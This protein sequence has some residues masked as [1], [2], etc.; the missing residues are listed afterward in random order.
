MSK[1]I[2]SCDDYVFTLSNELKEL[3]AN[4]LRETA[5]SRDHALK[6]MREWIM[7]NPRI[8]N[9]RLDANFL[10]RFLRSKKFS[11]PITQ[12]SLERYLLLRQSYDGRIFRNMDY[13]LNPTQELITNG[14]I[15]ALPQ[16]D[17]LGRR[18]VLTRPGVFDPYK[19]ANVD[20]LKIHG[21]TY[22]VL[23]ENEENQI[24]GFVHIVDGAGVNLPYMTI[25]TPKEAVRIVKNAERTL[26]MRHKEIKAFNLHGSI[27]FAV[28]FALGLVS[29]KMKN[30]IRIYTSVESAVKTVD[31]SLLPKEY[32]GVTPMSDMIAMWQDELKASRDVIL[33][34]DKMQVNLEMYSAKARQGAVS[35]LT[36]QMSNCGSEQDANLQ[37]LQGSFR[38]LEV[39]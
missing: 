22:E 7:S 4:E 5:S 13:L 27:K 6:A 16:R 17:K 31:I 35:A 14:Y 34:N 38:K 24:R 25:F 37:G 21:L 2:T 28:D 10:L 39:D 29:E 26:P 32:G 12:E 19:Y 9:V 11:V 8:S 23:L 1:G 3:A 18:I 30:R 15:F 33:M 36:Q 20:L